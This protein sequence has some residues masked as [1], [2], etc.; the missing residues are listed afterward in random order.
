[1][2]SRVTYVVD[3][4]LAELPAASVATTEIGMRVGD[5]GIGS[6]PSVP[7]KALLPAEF[8]VTVEVVPFKV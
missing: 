3:A 8:I 1:M 4:D 7:R 6:G 2:L 5:F